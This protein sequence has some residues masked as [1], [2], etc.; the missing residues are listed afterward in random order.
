[1]AARVLLVTLIQ[2]LA[3]SWGGDAGRDPLPFLEMCFAAVSQRHAYDD[4]AG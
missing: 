4:C 1:M 2:L 3:L